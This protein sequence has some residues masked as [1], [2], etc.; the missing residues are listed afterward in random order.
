MGMVIQGKF[1]RILITKQI[2]VLTLDEMD[3]FLTTFL[4]AGNFLD[5]GFELRNYQ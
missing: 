4:C 3:E 2:R 1:D 5:Q